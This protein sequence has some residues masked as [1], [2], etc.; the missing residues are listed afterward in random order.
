MQRSR[1]EG[2]KKLCQD[3]KREIAAL[4]SQLEDKDVKFA[5]K[6]REEQYEWEQ[7]IN[8]V[9]KLNEGELVRKQ[10]E[11]KKLNELLGKWIEGFQMMNAKGQKQE[12]I[13]L[14]TE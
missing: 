3:C 10:R 6:L 5:Q 7:A 13:N 11:I 4:K 8:Q 9:K 12:I 1:A 2:L 14:V